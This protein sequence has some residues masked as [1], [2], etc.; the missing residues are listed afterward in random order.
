MVDLLTDIVEVA[1]DAAEDVK[2]EDE[3]V[4]LLFGDL[5]V[6]ALEYG[7]SSEYI[8]LWIHQKYL[9]LRHSA[10]GIV[11]LVISTFSPAGFDGEFPVGVLRVGSHI[12]SNLPK[13]K[14]INFVEVRNLVFTCCSALPQF[15]R[16]RRPCTPQNLL[17]S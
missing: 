7:Q 8:L 15:P 10:G 13:Y 2:L 11:S 16:V 5:D 3:R 14:K 1:V 17:R 9:T 4:F 6:A 12:S